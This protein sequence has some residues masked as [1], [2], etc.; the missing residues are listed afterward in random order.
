VLSA[1]DAYRRAMREFAGQS[2]LAV[3]YAHQAV[4]P[5]LPGLSAVQSQ[6]ARRTVQKTVDEARMRDKSRLIEETY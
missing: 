4:Q 5:G 3:W 6:K 2:N 1:V